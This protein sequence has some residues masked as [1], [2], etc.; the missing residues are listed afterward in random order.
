MKRRDFGSAWHRA[1]ALAVAL[2]GVLTFSSAVTPNLPWREN[3]LVTIEPGPAIALGHVLAAAAGIVLAWLAPGLARGKGRAVTPTIT[4]LCVAAGLHA[5]KGLDYEEASVAVA[6]AL[7]LYL[8][9]RGFARGGDRPGTVVVAGVVVVAA[10]AAY[11]LLSTI[12]LLVSDRA[13]TLGSGLATAGNALT[14]G[15]WW[16]RSG[17]ALSLVLDLLLLVSLGAGFTLLRAL[18]RPA[19]S[20]DGHSADEHSRAA[21]IVAQHGDD[22]LAPFVLREDKAFFFSRGGLLAYR[23]LRGTAVVSG[24]PI[25]PPGSPALIL[26]DFLELAD[27]RGW[28]VVVTAAS[29][30]HLR[31]Y[32]KTLG[33]HALPIGNEAVVDPAGFS[34]E[35][36]AVRKVRQSVRRVERR[37]WHIEVVRAD[38]L[39]PETVAEIRQVQDAW[40]AEQPGLTGFAMTLGRLW[41]AAEDTDSLYVLARDP[42]GQVA[43]F[44]HFVPYKDGLSLDA[45]RRI[46]DEP[47]GLNEALVV[48]ALE[49]AREVGL[50]EVS[51]NFAGFAHIMAADAALTRR[52]R[53]L[54]ALLRCAHGRFQL[55]RIVRFN[56]K[57]FPSWRPRFLV[58]GT[59]TNLPVAALRVLQAE[60]YVR[61]PRPNPVT[62]GWQPLPHPVGALTTAAR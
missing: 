18:M 60:A 55:E 7:L 49:Y 56:E 58:Y 32:R 26:G 53:M 19:P 25:G 54:R 37:G 47:N 10:V 11:Y 24:D 50:R 30:R 40:A 21:T 27:Q 17:T 4:L 35:G 62:A 14:E 44:L 9:R 38:Q 45:M 29:E 8:G 51:L 15:G 28:D 20:A 52:Q 43:A 33:L 34:L 2:A 5:A 59:R 3:V 42:D 12:S 36:R 48:S 57:F 22:S 46:G 1:A 23:T 6:L 61:P 41:G 13:H 16:L 31:D 39:L